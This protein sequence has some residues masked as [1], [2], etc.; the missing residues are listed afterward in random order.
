MST[1]RKNL[2]DLNQ[3]DKQTM[4][5]VHFVLSIDPETRC[6]RFPKVQEENTVAGASCTNFK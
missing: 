5:L 4:Q 6:S 1:D 3:Q 2:M